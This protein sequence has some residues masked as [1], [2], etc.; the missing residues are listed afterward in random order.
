MENRIARNRKSPSNEEMY[1]HEYL[2]MNPSAK[3]TDGLD[4]AAV[5]T[6]DGI[7]GHGL[8]PEEFNRCHDKKNHIVKDFIPDSELKVRN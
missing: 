6:K 7:R 2:R 3:K 4:I 5:I 1:I 8:L